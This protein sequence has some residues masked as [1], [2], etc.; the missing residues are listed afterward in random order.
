MAVVEQAEGNLC[1]NFPDLPGC[2]ATGADP[3]EL[4]PHLAVALQWHLEAL[5]A[6]GQAPPPPTA[7]VLHVDI[8][9]S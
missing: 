4:K 7:R 6:Q 5:Q 1:A 9:T 2:V 8:P 3:D